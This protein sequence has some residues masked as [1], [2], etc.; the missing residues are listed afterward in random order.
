M[1]NTFEDFITNFPQKILTS[2]LELHL[3]NDQMLFYKLGDLAFEKL[4][5]L[6]GPYLN[7]IKI[8]QMKIFNTDNLQDKCVI[9]T[10][11]I[12][13][14][15]QNYKNIDKKYYLIIS[16]TDL[17]VPTPHNKKK[18][19]ELLNSEHLIKCF[20]VNRSIT[21]NKL[22]DFPITIWPWFKKYISEMNINVLPERKKLCF[23]GCWSDTSNQ[24]YQK[25]R[26][27]LRHMLK[28]KKSNFIDVLNMTGGKDY[29][30]LLLTYKYQISPR[31]C[32]VDCFRTWESLYLGCIPIILENENNK[33]Y[34]ELPVLIID[35]YSNITEQLL[36]EHYEKCKK[37]LFNLSIFKEKYWKDL[38]S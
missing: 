38:M 28:N 13:K 35:D 6:H 4:F 16:F 24:P 10:I 2:N 34:E 32:G 12:D 26:L 7:Y 36:L 27:S 23:G 25:K 1:N 37:K 17:N 3:Y 11:D 22:Y 19:I 18:F 33:I 15:I 29:I 8:E 30:T 20:T 14:F 21:H 31:G 9:V 5:Y